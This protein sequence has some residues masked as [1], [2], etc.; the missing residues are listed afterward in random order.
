MKKRLLSLV[1][2][3]M[4]VMS[5][6]TPASAAKPGVETKSA[7]DIQET[8]V[9]M[10][11][12]VTSN[13]GIRIKEYGFMFVNDGNVSYKKFV[14]GK[15]FE[16]PDPINN[17]IIECKK[18]GLKAGKEYCYQFYAINENDEKSVG[19]S[20]YFTTKKKSSSGDTEKPDINDFDC[21]EGASFYVGQ[22]VKFYA[23]TKDNDK[24]AEV[25]LYIDGKKVKTSDDGYISYKTSDLSAGKHTIKVKVT[26]A[27]G[28]YREEDMTVTVKGK[29]KLAAPVLKPKKSTIEVSEVLELSWNSVKN[30]DYYTVKVWETGFSES[31]FDTSTE[32]YLR[33]ITFDKPGT[34][35]VSIYSRTNN[36][37]EFEQSEPYGINITV[38]EGKCSHTPERQNEK[39]RYDQVSSDT[40]HNMTMYFDSVCSKC[41]EVLQSKSA[42]KT[43]KENH[44]FS[45]DK[46]TKCGYTKKVAVEAVCTHKNTTTAKKNIVKKPSAISGND[47]QHN[48]TEYYDVVCKCGVTIDYD[49]K[50]NTTKAS[51]SFSDNKCTACGYTKKAVVEETVSPQR[52]ATPVVTIKKTTVEVGEKLNI[53]WNKVPNA[54]YYTIHCWTTGKVYEK[55]TGTS[56]N[57]ISFDK[58]GTYSIAVYAQSKTPDKY[59]QSEPPY[60][61]SITVTDGVCTHKNTTTS[62]KNI[63]KKPTAISGNDVQ[64]NVTEYYD[65]VCKCGVTISSDVKGNT[66]KASHSF[67]D[68]TCTA[69][70]YTKKVVEETNKSIFV[71]VSNNASYLDEIIYL[72]ERNI[73]TGKPGNKFDPNGYL[74]RAEAATIICRMSS[75]SQKAKTYTG[76]PDVPSSHWASGYIKSAKDNG[77]VA[78]R[79]TGKFDPEGKLTGFEFVKMVVCWLGYGDE[80]ISAYPNETWANQYYYYAKNYLGLLKNMPTGGYNEYMKRSNAAVLAY[81]ALFTSKS[82]E[83]VS[84]KNNTTVANGSSSDTT[85]TIAEMLAYAKTLVDNKNNTYAYGA[86]GEANSRGG[87][88]FDCSGFTQYVFAKFGV[89]IPRNSAAQASEKTKVANAKVENGTITNI[90]PGDILFSNNGTYNHVVIYAGNNKYYHAANSTDGLKEGSFYPDYLNNEFISAHRYEFEESSSISNSLGNL[91]DKA[92]DTLQSIGDKLDEIFTTEVGNPSKKDPDKVYIQNEEPFKRIS[93]GYKDEECEKPT[94]IGYSGCGVIALA[95]AIHYISGYDFK[96]TDIEDIAKYSISKGYRKNGWGTSKRISEGLSD[97]YGYKYR[98]KSGAQYRVSG[99]NF[100]IV[101]NQINSCLDSNGAIYFSVVRYEK[102]AKGETIAHGH[103]MCIV[104]RR[105]NKDG[106][107]EYLVLDSYPSSNRLGSGVSW[108]WCELTDDLD[109]KVGSRKII[110]R[111]GSDSSEYGFFTIYPLS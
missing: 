93:Y 14:A 23:D 15:D 9:V 107:S 53:S 78:G 31:Y 50:G 36:H 109:I 21:S 33:K 4:I 68:N 41:G 79:N 83:D 62:K 85:G 98:F 48:V 67:S 80:A 72:N 7:K 102:N 86:T 19:K 73:I 60:S 49:V 27:S 12:A 90:Q 5:F 39:P 43:E 81:N 6:I 91:V 51:H 69:C 46:C 100:E 1:L 45:G 84:V 88:K 65:V 30:A 97:D 110:T 63:E 76:F 94:D 99:N 104:N 92:K 103:I 101:R 96:K 35:A 66:T 3:M 38:V 24:V 13:S 34:Y 25:I 58:N 18:T 22:S 20:V 71:D 11:G 56:Y 95:N 44:S 57:S 16:Y 26:D 52:L 64:H 106:K 89:E 10:R 17:D 47:V 8:S 59:P 111:G 55:I 82:T 42:D 40:Y 37:D 29:E 74:T 75:N 54:D 2:A 32:G 61:T 105:I 87:Q 70:G 28:N 77:I 108:K